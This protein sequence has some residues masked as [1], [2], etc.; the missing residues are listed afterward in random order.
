MKYFSMKHVLYMKY[1]FV[2]IWIFL[3]IFSNKPINP[4]DPNR[5][6]WFSYFFEKE[7]KSYQIDLM[8][9][10]L[11]QTFFWLKIDSNRTVTPLCWDLHGF[12]WAVKKLITTI[13]STL[14]LSYSP[15]FFYQYTL[16]LDSISLTVIRLP[17]SELC[18]NWIQA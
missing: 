17:K 9:I 8:K 10:S 3:I 16:C 18:K 4:T 1:K 12:G 5:L 15:I 6:I 14:V 7:W 2:R 13:Y 11:V